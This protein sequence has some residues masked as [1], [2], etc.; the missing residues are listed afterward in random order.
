MDRTGRLRLNMIDVYGERLSER[1]D[2]YLRHV[3]LSDVVAARNVDARKLTVVTGLYGTPRGSYRLSIDPP[4]YFSI[5]AI[6]NLHASEIT[7]RVYVFAVDPEK[8]I[9]VQFPAWAEIKIAQPLLEASGSVLGFEGTTG[10]KLYGALDDIRRA[11]LLNILAK[12]SRTGLPGGGLVSDHL[13]KLREIRGDRFFASVPHS[14]REHVKNSISAGR[15]QEVS[16]ALHRP[17][18]GF[19]LAGS[20]KTP[21]R[22]GN[23][24][25]TFFARGDEWVAEIDIDDASGLEHS[26]Q[27]LRNSITG[28][29]T[30]PFE[31]QQILIKEQEIDPG[32]KLIVREPAARA[33][34]QG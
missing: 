7:D 26:F 1:V 5:G 27:V 19:T 3:E 31:I 28:R 11:G 6:V 24:Q 22:Y 33:V 12:S 10:E 4:S 9:R 13:L 18:D 29:P 14:L 17:P 30:H 34:T 20:Y 16:G 32:Y 23:L 8:V 2:I 15:F 25:L 21:D